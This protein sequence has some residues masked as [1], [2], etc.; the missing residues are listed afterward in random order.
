MR[1]AYHD[2]TANPAEATLEALACDLSQR[3]HPGAAGS[4]RGRS[5]R[6]AH[7]RPSRCAADARQNAALDELH[8]VDDRDLPRPLEQRQA[9]AQRADGASFGARPGWSRPASSS[10]VSTASC[11]CRRCGLPSKRLSHP[12]TTL[13]ERRWR[14][15]RHAGGRH[16][17]STPVGK[18]TPCAPLR[19]EGRLLHP[20]AE[21]GLSAHQ[22][23]HSDGTA[24]WKCA[25]CRKQFSVITNTVMHGTKVPIRTWVFVLL[26]MVASKNGVAAEIERKYQV[27]PR[28]A[29]HMTQRI[30]AAM[31]NPIA[32]AVCSPGS[33]RRTRCTSGSAEHGKRVRHGRQGRGGHRGG[34]RW[35]GRVGGSAE[36]QVQAVSD[37]GWTPF[38]PG[39]R[40]W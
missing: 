34:A 15:R 8:R 31:G 32:G 30:R 39:S 21:W 17:N 36:S 25:A 1:A 11:T 23:G 37:C 20:S 6:D 5:R 40:R 24:P 7:H 18:G 27:T 22:D 19:S 10:A 4:L 16:R 29:W 13:L 35:P 28:T 38:V 33:W 3:S 9:L 2:E 26:E 12:I 14:H